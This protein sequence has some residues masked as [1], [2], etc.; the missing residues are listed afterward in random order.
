VAVR[1]QQLQLAQID[2]NF[3]QSRS[4]STKRAVTITTSHADV[5]HLRAV[6]PVLG[7]SEADAIELLSE[8]TIY[9]QSVSNLE[10]V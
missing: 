9:S 4:L 1:F 5:A 7:M 3:T 8:S 6:V 10:H 2:Q